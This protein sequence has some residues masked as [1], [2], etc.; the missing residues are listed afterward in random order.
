MAKAQHTLRWIVAEGMLAGVMVNLVSGVFLVKLALDL[1][2]SPWHIG[3]L[4]ALPFLGQLVQLPAIFMLARLGRRKL[5]SVT[6]SI[7]HRIAI[8]LTVPVPFV[9]DKALALKLLILLVL[10]RE[11]GLG[12]SSGGWYG[13]MRDLMPKNMVSRIFGRRLYLF[14]FVGTA[15]ALTAGMAVDWAADA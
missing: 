3:L 14:T 13:W 5:V 11:C 2:D 4:S 10:I 7:I 1:G 6:G 9:E 12:W 15:F 8:L